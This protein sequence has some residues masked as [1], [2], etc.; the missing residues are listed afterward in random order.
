M[1]TALGLSPCP[2]AAPPYGGNP[3]AL[4][5]PGIASLLGPLTL[6]RNCF[7]GHADHKFVQNKHLG[8]LGLDEYYISLSAPSITIPPL[9]LSLSLSLKR[10]VYGDVAITLNVNA[11]LSAVP[12]VCDANG[13]KAQSHSPSSQVGKQL[14]GL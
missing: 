6:K 3:P 7:I 2:H 5:A 4:L 9:S 11:G 14:S 12:S 8:R 1:G 13:A 10:L